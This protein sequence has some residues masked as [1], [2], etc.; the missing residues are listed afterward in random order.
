MTKIKKKVEK[1][2]YLRQKQFFSKRFFFKNVFFYLSANFSFFLFNQ[3]LGLILVNQTF[4]A[5]FWK[6]HFLEILRKIPL[7]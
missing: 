7:I 3:I 5:D 1:R 4:L 6:R 2:K